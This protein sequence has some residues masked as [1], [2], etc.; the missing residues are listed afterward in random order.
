VI[1]A[2]SRSDSA[3]AKQRAAGLIPV[4]GDFADPGSL[5]APAAQVDAIVS[6]ANIGQ[7]EGTPDSFA[8]DRDAVA[9][10]TKALGDSGK[11]QRF[12]DLRDLHQGRGQSDGFRRR[13]SRS[14]PRLRLRAAGGRDPRAVH[15]RLRRRNGAARRNGSVREIAI[16]PG[17]VY[18]E[19]KVYDLPNL[20][21]LA[22]TPGAAPHLGAGGVRQG[23]VRP[24]PEIQSAVVGGVIRQDR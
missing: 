20:I 7:V 21:A 15:R 8:K 5:A 23:Y 9:V 24:R 11:P 22:K 6:T 12:G 2:L 10:I 14:A 4:F 1:L 19:G 3:A 13:L 18:G 17:L 16:R